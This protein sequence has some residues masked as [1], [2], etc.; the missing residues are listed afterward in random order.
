MLG[1]KFALLVRDTSIPEE[2]VEEADILAE[3]IGMEVEGIRYHK[4]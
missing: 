3:L 1:C 4:I 2:L